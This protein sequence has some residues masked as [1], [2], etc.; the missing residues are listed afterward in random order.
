MAVENTNAL[1]QM[2][3][4]QL[5]EQYFKTLQGLE[6]GQMITG[7]IVQISTENV[8][9]DVGYKSEGKIPIGEFQALPKTGEQVQVVLVRKESR[10][11]SI[12]VS[13]AKADEKIFWRNLRKAHTEKL[14]V[15]GKITRQVKGGYSVDLGSGVTA[16]LPLSKTD[17][18]RVN[19][20]EEYV[21]V[22]SKFAIER[23]FSNGKVNIVLSR[24]AWL[25]EEY[26]RRR[27][28]FFTK[29]QIGDE[30]EGRGKTFTSFGAFIDLGGFDG[31]LHINDM[32]WGHVNTPKERVTLGDT[33]RLKVINLDAENQR[34]N[35]SLKHFTEDPWNRFEEKFQ[36]GD[37]VHGSVTKLTDFG[38]FIELEEGIE[39]L[40]HISEFSWVK[41]VRHPREVLH[42][43][44]KVDV[45][46]LDY[47]VTQ[48]KVS[49][50]LKQVHAN[51][52]SDIDSRFPVGMRI[53]RKVKNLAAFGAF[54]ELEEGID[55]L[56]HL[57]DFSWTKHH[58]H[59]S[60]VL[61]EDDEVEVMVIGIDKES[62]RI[63]LG[64]KQLDEDPWR[65]LQKAFPRGSVIEGVVGRAADFGLFV[66]VQGDI[67]GLIATKNL[68]DPR[69]ETQQDVL[70]SL[71][72]G[73]PIRAVVIEVNPSRQKLGL[74]RVDFMKRSHEE[75]MSKYLH[76]EGS[77]DKVTLGDLLKDKL[78]DT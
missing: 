22:Q 58:K 73:E 19:N 63:R 11:G 34:I 3:D 48:G 10:D 64:L 75:E 31:L 77:S 20:V 24:R 57:D 36:S 16:F 45:K 67:E 21:G 74:S 53:R 61:K 62:Q 25:E 9:V 37:V 38:A 13:K 4:S 65:S 54:F 27:E 52:W 7:T 68:F 1:D 66:K 23:L 26:R 14:P 44:D 12:A 69:S 43:G 56:L 42:V 59:P 50:G 70:A 60:E 72:E 6:E 17:V 30:V 2:A 71:K 78:T 46:I 8:F 55:G 35:L 41:R 29:T 39:G 76:S 33:I 28:E 18:Y 32:S 15:E 51:P 49:L 40:A 47:D 5:E